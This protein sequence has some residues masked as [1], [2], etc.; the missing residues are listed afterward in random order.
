LAFFDLVLQTGGSLHPGD[1]SL[2]VTTYTGAIRC[3]RSSDG[4]VCRVGTIVAHRIHTDLAWRDSAVVRNA[5]E[6]HSRELQEVYAALFDV[7]EDD[8]SIDIRNQFDTVT[9]DVLVL[10]YILLNPRWRGV[11]LGLLAVRKLID[12]LGGGCGVVA[13]RLGPLN[14]KA[15]K[16]RE[17]SP[18]WLPRLAD[19]NEVRAARRKLRRYFRRVGFERIPGTR[20]HGLSL[21]R[22]TP[23]LADLL[24]PGKK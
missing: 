21:N 12:L 22:Y 4:K 20:L 1:P 5:C 3:S 11:K 9:S 15:A 10:D 14:P 7:E 23:T 16:C 2:Y 8:L 6:A 13:A 18:D 17:L 19:Q 24:R